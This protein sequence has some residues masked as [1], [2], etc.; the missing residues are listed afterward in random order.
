MKQ[1]WWKA[2]GAFFLAAL[3]SIPAWGAVPPHPGTLN[4]IEGQ[5]SIGNQ[6]LTEKSVGSAQ[7]AAG[8][9]LTTQ[10]GRAEVLLTPGIFLR[11]DKHSSV[12]MVNPGLADTIVKLDNGRTMVEV[13]ELHNANNVR[14]NEDGASVRLLKPG[15]YEFNAGRGTVQVFDGKASVQD[16]DRNTT[17]KGGH[18]VVLNASNKKLKAQKFDKNASKDDFYRWASLRS[19]YLAEANVDT[20]RAY[21]GGAGWYPGPW[22]G[23]GWYWDP[24]FSAYTFVPGA[25]LWYDPFGWGF[26]SPVVVGVAPYFGFGYGYPYYH[27]FG[28]GYRPM[29]GSSG[30]TPGFVAGG[31]GYGTTSR[32]AFGGPGGGFNGRTGGFNRRGFGGGGFHGGGFHGG[33]FGGFHGGFGGGFHGGGGRR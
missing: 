4:Y 17:V 23:A 1:S 5:A 20:A 26:Y 25:G 28:P 6:N 24:W 10:N 32:G 18:E 31:R 11:I 27:H 33:G 29:Y 22:Y 14:V 2:V 7:L 8:Q 12:Q 30:H 21:A 9:T 3:I 15:L 19:S 13:T 16:N